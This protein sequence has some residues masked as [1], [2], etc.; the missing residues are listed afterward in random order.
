MDRIQRELEER[1][2]P[3]FMD[4]EMEESVFSEKR[5]KQKR[6]LRDVLYGKMPFMDYETTFRETGKDPDAYGGR[7]VL[8]HVLV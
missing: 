8:Y 1:R 6:I 5:K 2:L 3:D 7:A 4:K